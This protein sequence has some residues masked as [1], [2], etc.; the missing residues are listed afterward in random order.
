[1]IVEIIVE[2]FVVAGQVRSSPSPNSREIL[3][4]PKARP[5]CGLGD[6]PKIGRARA[7]TKLCRRR[8]FTSSIHQAFIQTDLFKDQN[9]AHPPLDF[10]VVRLSF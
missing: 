8:D 3:R 4:I 6:R 9:S 2:S 10:S 7:D 1:M 5:A